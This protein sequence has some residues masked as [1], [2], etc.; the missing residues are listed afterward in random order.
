MI[1]KD[2][3]YDLIVADNESGGDPHEKIEEEGVSLEAISYWTEESV[4][5]FNFMTALG[6][7]VAEA[8]HSIA[9]ASFRLGMA[10]E[11]ELYSQAERAAEVV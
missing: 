3:F 8:I 7:P 10:V 11:R 6:V 2:Q 5:G 4:N 9:F 1:T